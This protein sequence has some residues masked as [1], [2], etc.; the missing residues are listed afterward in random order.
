MHDR[1]LEILWVRLLILEIQ[2]KS[3]VRRLMSREQK[4]TEKSENELMSTKI[5]L[6]T[7]TL[8]DALS[9]TSYA[10]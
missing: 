8:T 6:T 9:L 7:Q 4:H 3:G 5:L 10:T 1:D 2:L